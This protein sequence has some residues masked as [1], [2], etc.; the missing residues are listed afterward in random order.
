MAVF[1]KEH[2]MDEGLAQGS[3]SLRTSIDNGM[4]KGP[5]KGFH[6]AGSP[7]TSISVKTMEDIMTEFAMDYHADNVEAVE[8]QVDTPPIDTI[9]P[10]PTNDQDPSTALT[11]TMASLPSMD[12]AM[13]TFIKIHGLEELGQAKEHGV[14]DIAEARV[15]IE[16]SKVHNVEEFIEDNDDSPASLLL[17]L[18]VAASAA[19]F[20]DNRYLD[21]DKYP[22]ADV[23]SPS[24]GN[25][26]LQ[27]SAK[28]TS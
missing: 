2:G 7:R 3:N 19:S 17:G 23:K 12:D 28:Q 13:A 22:Q 14:E 21:D 15:E 10:I 1:A 16:Q 6:I 5:T 26:P 4:D 20:N 27:K 8:P 18:M 24:T 25:R 9:D 11:N